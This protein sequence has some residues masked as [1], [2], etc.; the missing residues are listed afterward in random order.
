MRAKH[1]YGMER[2]QRK[3]R[4]FIDEPA[5]LNTISPELIQ[6]KIIPHLLP[7]DLK[8]VS[9]TSQYLKRT[10]EDSTRWKMDRFARELP[11]GTKIR[12]IFKYDKNVLFSKKRDP[13]EAEVVK[14]ECTQIEGG[15]LHKT[16]LKLDGE[17][18]KVAYIINDDKGLTFKEFVEITS[19]NNLY[20]RPYR[21]KSLSLL[22]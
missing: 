21:I 2:K 7:S 20:F 9:E 14:D 4:P 6:E 3:Q 13:A 22:D 19:G 18:R 17:D 8:N 5:S 1:P 15:F 10:A 11:K 12:V 16:V